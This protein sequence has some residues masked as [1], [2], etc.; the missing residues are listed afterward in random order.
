MSTP[1]EMERLARAHA[2]AVLGRGVWPDYYAP[3]QQ[4]DYLSM[5]GM[6]A[7]IR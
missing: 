4:E 5:M 1:N 3:G 7:S 6:R 2:A